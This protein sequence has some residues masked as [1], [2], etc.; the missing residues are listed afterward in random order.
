[1]AQY[2]Q[3]GEK[4]YRWG[5]TVRKC[6]QTLWGAL[7]QVHIPRL[8]ASRRWGCLEKYQRHGL[9]EVLFALAV[10]GLSWRKGAALSRRD[11]LAGHDRR[12]PG[13]R[14]ATDP[15]AQNATAFGRHLPRPGGAWHA[16]ALS[17]AGG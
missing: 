17:P 15:G 11:A 3:R 13:A 8:R 1:M 2:R 14:P 9:Q 12:G 6:W 7:E 10:G 4:V 16:S 5:Y